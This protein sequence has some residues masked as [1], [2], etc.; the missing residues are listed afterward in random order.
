MQHW[1]SEGAVKADAVGIYGWSVNYLYCP[2]VGPLYRRLSPL[3][4]AP[5][6]SALRL[7]V[8]Q[9]CHLSPIGCLVACLGAWAVCAHAHAVCFVA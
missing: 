3:Y 7:P 5:M 2:P 4:T 8:S 1:I 9:A 6:G